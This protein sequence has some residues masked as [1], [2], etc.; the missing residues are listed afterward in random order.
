MFNRNLIVVILFGACLIVATIGTKSE[1]LKRKNG[2]SSSS[3]EIYEIFYDKDV[4][5]TKMVE[6]RIQD[7]PFSK[8]DDAVN[9][10]AEYYNKLEPM[11]ESLDIGTTEKEDDKVCWRSLINYNLSVCCLKIGRDGS[12]ELVGVNLLYVQT[13]NNESLEEIKP[14]MADVFD[15]DVFSTYN[16]DYYLSSDGILVHPDYRGRK[17]GEKMLRAREAICRKHDIEVTSSVFTSDSSNIIAERAGFKHIDVAVSWNEFRR[18]YPKSRFAAIK[19]SFITRR[20]LKF[21]LSDKKLKSSS[22]RK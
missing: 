15:F 22:F 13:P 9:L 6:Y 2:E 19:D 18:K 16:V 4:N 1:K 7:I 10:M 8:F 20:T 21:K 12:E 14:D 5:S 17:I 11:T 3:D